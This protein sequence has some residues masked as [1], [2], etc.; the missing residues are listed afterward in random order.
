GRLPALAWTMGYMRRFARSITSRAKKNM[1]AW[2]QRHEPDAS[3]QSPGVFGT[4]TL[5]RARS[6]PL[7]GIMMMS[8]PEP[9]P[10]QPS[11]LLRIRDASVEESWRTFVSIY[12]ALIYRSC[13]RRG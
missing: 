9:G 11:L 8:K 6:S 4:M 10:T 13:R 1:Q 3:L 7:V 12:A 5:L 2:A